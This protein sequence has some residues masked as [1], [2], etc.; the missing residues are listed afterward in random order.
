MTAGLAL[1]ILDALIVALTWP[2]TLWFL[3][4]GAQ[5]PSAW[6]QALS[7]ASSNLILLYALGFYRRDSLADT[8]RAVGR[9]PLAVTIGAIAASLVSAI[10][11]WPLSARF[12]IAA[13]L[14]FTTCA[15]LARLVFR[16]LRHH[17][18]CSVPI[19]W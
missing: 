8:A 11:I 15:M 13:I 16:A 12:I 10:L 6:L 4:G 19:F 2:F 7:F 1:F 3:L 17:N 14:C 18:S 9:V 5:S